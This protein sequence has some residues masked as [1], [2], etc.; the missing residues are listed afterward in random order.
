VQSAVQ[1]CCLPLR[2]QRQRNAG[3]A[4]TEEESVGAVEQVKA[5]AFAEWPVA[6]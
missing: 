6:R 4:A 2:H 5:E 1:L 3:E